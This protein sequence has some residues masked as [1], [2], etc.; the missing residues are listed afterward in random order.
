MAILKYTDKDGNEVI[1][2]PYKVV[3]IP[4]VQE[5]G[6]SLESVMSQNSTTQEITSLSVL[7]ETLT[8]RITE[9]ETELASVKETVNGHTT[10]ISTLNDDM[11]SVESTLT[12]HGE[13]ITALN[14]DLSTANTNI[15]TLSSDMSSVQT[16]VGNHT[17]SL[18]TLNTKVT[19]QGTS[20]S[21]VSGRVTTL[22]GYNPVVIL[23]QAEYDALP[24][25]DDRILYITDD[26]TSTAS[27]STLSD[28]IMITDEPNLLM[29]EDMISP[30]MMENADIIEAQEPM[31][32]SENNEL[33]NMTNDASN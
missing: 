7:I 25:K 1:V 29:S 6:D 31:V 33:E 13:S 17:T 26:S 30:M 2:T 4:V 9:L 3:N 21:S 5:T 27:V 22:E 8:T 18:D 28:D 19:N 16:T 24:T 23:T 32:E 12:N 10:S 15:S 20:I 14:T 11:D